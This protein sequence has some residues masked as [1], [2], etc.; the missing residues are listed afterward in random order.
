MFLYLPIA[1]VFAWWLLSSA[2]YV[3]HYGLLR[4]KDSEGHFESCSNQHAWNSNYL[5][6]NLITLQVQR[7]SDHHLRPS[8]PYQVLEI[9]SDMPMLPQG[10]PAMFLLAA[11]PPLWYAVID[12]ILLKLVNYDLDRINID[13]EKRQRLYAK[14]SPKPGT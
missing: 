8:E 14:Y 13:P 12:P 2:S 7:H 1:A 4:Q 3:E 6:S 10:Y 11:V 5:V 9:S